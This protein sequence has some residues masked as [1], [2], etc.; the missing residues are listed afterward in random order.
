MSSNV[1]YNFTGLNLINIL[2]LESLSMI[3]EY[4]QFSNTSHFLG[5]NNVNLGSDP[6]IST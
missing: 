6:Q 2:H 4:F 3:L 1:V 5:K